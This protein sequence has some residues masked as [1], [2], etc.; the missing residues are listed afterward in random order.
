MRAA[1][2]ASPRSPAAQRS[3]GLGLQAD[4]PAR[5]PLVEVGEELGVAIAC[6]RREVERA[7]RVQ[8]RPGRIRLQRVLPQRIGEQEVR[9][10]PGT[11]GLRL[12]V[13]LPAEQR[14]RPPHASVAIEYHQRLPGLEV[15]RP[16]RGLGRDRHERLDQTPGVLDAAE[17][18]EGV[19]ADHDRADPVEAA[20]RE[21]VD[22]DERPLVPGHD[23]QPGPP[24]PGLKAADRAHVG[25]R[26][27]TGERPLDVARR[28]C[29]IEARERLPRRLDEEARRALRVPRLLG[30]LGEH[31]RL[32]MAPLQVLPREPVRE[33]AIFLGKQAVCCIA[34]Q[35]VAKPVHLPIGRLRGSQALEELTLD[36]H[37]KGLLGPAAAR[38]GAEQ[39]QRP[40]RGEGLPEDR[41]CAEQVAGLRIELREP[42]DQHGHHRLGQGV[43]PPLGH[44][45]DQL[46][47][48]ERVTAR[49]RHDARHPLAAHGALRAEH[50]LHEALARAAA[51]GAERQLLEEAGAPEGGELPLHLGPR[52]HQDE[53]RQLRQ[54][55]ERL[56]QELHRQGIPPVQVFR[57]EE[58]R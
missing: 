22:R 21:H 15:G 24:C 8:E 33:L 35:R 34:H 54:L 25:V 57:D 30:V 5:E 47:E 38:A 29:R 1:A 26:H 52:E 48:E 4:R 44:C 28:R 51:Q 45:P 42:G 32:V 27:P 11:Y 36:Q 13:E 43:F 37:G 3:H 6:R 18:E 19:E 23:V 53:E 40:G 7:P 9:A 50:L 41:A 56:L 58:D 46:L 17:H 2:R 49:L 12:A 16:R 10:L 20:R 39:R 55:G 14:S 31:R